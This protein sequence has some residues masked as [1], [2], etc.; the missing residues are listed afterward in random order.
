MIEK[1]DPADLL[2]IAGEAFQDELLPRLPD[3]ARYTGLLVAAAVAVA[4]RE[5]SLGPAQLAAERGR[6]CR[7]YSETPDPAEDAAETVRRLNRRLAADIRAG[8]F[9][10]PGPRRDAAYDAVRAA[11]AAGVAVSNPRYR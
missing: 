11:A 9:D 7:L 10:T 8:V 2:R 5:A 1:L 6:L 3:V 4:A